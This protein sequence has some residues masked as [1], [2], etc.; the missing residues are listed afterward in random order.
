MFNSYLS[1]SVRPNCGHILIL[2]DSLTSGL[3][4]LEMQSPEGSSYVVHHDRWLAGPGLDSAPA[5]LPS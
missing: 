1:K 5:P 3:C 4:L 2:H